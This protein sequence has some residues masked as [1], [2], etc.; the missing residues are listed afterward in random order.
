MV[1]TRQNLLCLFKIVFTH[2]LGLTLL[3]LVSESSGTYFQQLLEQLGL[4]HRLGFLV[5]RDLS[6]RHRDL[7]LVV[8]MLFFFGVLWLF[9]LLNELSFG[10]AD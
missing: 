7:L 9:W 2:I 5:L 8:G 6:V 10:R 3:L 1:Y 4:H